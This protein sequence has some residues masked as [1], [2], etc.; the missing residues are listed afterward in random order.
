[1]NKTFYT[2]YAGTKYP[3]STLYRLAASLT[4]FNAN[5][6]VALADVPLGD[7]YREVVRCPGNVVFTN[8]PTTAY[9]E[10]L[11]FMPHRWWWKMVF[12]DH[13]WGEDILFVDLDTVFMKDPAPIFEWIQDRKPSMA[14][15]DDWLTDRPATCLFCLADASPEPALIWNE[16]MQHTACPSQGDQQLVQRA[17]ANKGL[18]YFHFPAEFMCSYK[19]MW[20]EGQTTPAWR[21]AKERKY[22]YIRAED[23]ISYTFNGK[24]SL[25]EVLKRRLHG[26][27]FFHGMEQ[28]KT[29]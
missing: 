6:I 8:I 7:T 27:E 25:D 18:A 4:R 23:V 13:G 5:L 21:Q 10:K 15:T 12:Y 24:P 26:W 29:A 16:F 22:D 9:A 28:N 2:L 11:G 17:I 14:F 19:V 1:M 20:P 3:P